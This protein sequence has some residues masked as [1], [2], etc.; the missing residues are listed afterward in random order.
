MICFFVLS[1]RA[2]GFLFDRSPSRSPTSNSIPSAGGARAATVWTEESVPS[3]GGARAATVW[4]ETS[5]A[6]MQGISLAVVVTTA[7]CYHWSNRQVN[8]L[9]AADEIEARPPRHMWIE[10][11]EF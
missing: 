7:L 10:D 11:S 2:K 5:V 3:A 4:R 9:E 6:W 8:K 1:A